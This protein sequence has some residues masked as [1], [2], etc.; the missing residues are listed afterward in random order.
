LNKILEHYK[1]TI[2]ENTP[3]EEEVALDPELL[4]LVFE[5]LLAEIDP[6]DAISKSA[7][8]A[9][10]SF[11]TPRKVI[12]YMVNESLLLYLKNNFKT[13]NYPIGYI[14]SKCAS[15]INQNVPVISI[16]FVPVIS[17]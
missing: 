1:F 12:D 11:Y 5:N 6:N 13:K 7:R 9:T 8:K 15:C 10:G 14:S 16:E 2:D 17:A 4:G 3:L